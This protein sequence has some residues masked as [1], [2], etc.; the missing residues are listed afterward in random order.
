MIIT[1]QTHFFLS[2]KRS[3]ILTVCSILPP[4]GLLRSYLG[5][6][7]YQFIY[8]LLNTYR[9][10][11]QTLSTDDIQPQVLFLLTEEKTL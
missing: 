3:F 1:L 9:L 5:E 8:R 6:Y 11:P 2:M 7:I 10:A 4:Q